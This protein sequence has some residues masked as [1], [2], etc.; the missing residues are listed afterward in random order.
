MRPLRNYLAGRQADE[1]EDCELLRLLGGHRV[2]QIGRPRIGAG[3]VAD[4]LHQRF[5]RVAVDA[6]FDDAEHTRPTGDQVDQGAFLELHTREPSEQHQ[7]VG[8]R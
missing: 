1:A 2:G 4:G 6:E 8:I 7:R 3:A 5:G